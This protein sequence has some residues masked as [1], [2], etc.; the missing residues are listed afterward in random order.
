MYFSVYRFGAFFFLLNLFL[1]IYFWASLMAQSVKNLPAMQETWV[2]SLGWED[3]LEE[4][5][6]QPTPVFLPGESPWTEGPGM[7]Q[8]MG[9]KESDTTEWLSTSI[10][11]C[12][13]QWDCF[14]FSFVFFI[15]NIY[16]YN[17][18][19]YINILS[20]TLFFFSFIFI[21]WRLITLQYCSGFCHTLTW[22]SHGFTSIPHPH[23]P[24]HLP[25]YPIP[26][27]LPSAPGPSTCLMYPTWADDLFHPR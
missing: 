19:L 20:C 25:L 3:P 9:C 11:C 18:F 24:S 5:T 1:L 27:G 21:S 7:L 14:N 8:S 2:R 15:A 4:R 10:F 6:W 13:Y 22:I 12:Y 26:L 16:K 17:Y 23:P